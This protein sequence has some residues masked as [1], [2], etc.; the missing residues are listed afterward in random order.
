MSLWAAVTCVG[1]NVTVLNPSMLGHELVGDGISKIAAARNVLS[2]ALFQEV[3]ECASSNLRGRT[4]WPK[5]HTGDAAIEL[6]EPA[7]AI[8]IWIFE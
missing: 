2:L 4:D 3:R 5:V 8:A 6:G 1:S 7:P